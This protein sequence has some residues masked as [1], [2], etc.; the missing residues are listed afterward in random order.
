MS[1]SGTCESRPDRPLRAAPS[2][3]EW[4]LHFSIPSTTSF[5]GCVQQA[6]NTGVVT[7]KSR[8][9][10]IQVLQTHMLVHTIYPTSE[11]YIAVCQNL[12]TKCPK[13]KDAKETPIL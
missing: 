9:E 8:R 3:N 1:S 2:S 7:A 12:V 11:Q 13:L 4:H 10:I 5:L 6:I